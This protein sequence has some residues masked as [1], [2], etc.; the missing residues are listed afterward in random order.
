MQKDFSGSSNVYNPYIYYD[1]NKHKKENNKFILN[2]IGIIKEST[3]ILFVNS[4][5]WH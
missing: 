3:R 2:S 5:A 1:F 4:C